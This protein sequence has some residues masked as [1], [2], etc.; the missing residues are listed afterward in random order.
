MFVEGMTGFGLV[1]ADKICVG[2]GGGRGAVLNVVT[3]LV[4]ATTLLSIP[5]F[6]LLGV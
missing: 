5:Y 4:R 1:L 6:M 3:S 2:G